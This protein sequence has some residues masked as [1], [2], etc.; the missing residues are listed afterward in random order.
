MVV[1]SVTLKRI[2]KV[3]KKIQI[4]KKK[5]KKNPKNP[6]KNPKNPKKQKKIY[7]IPKK[8]KNY[9]KWSKNLKK[10]E[11][12]PL[13][14]MLSCQFSNIVRTRFDHSSPVQLVAESCGGN[15]EKPLNPL[16]P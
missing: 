8:S 4:K 10:S 15:P 16:N 12:I 6:K 9:P 14:K 2:Q 7:K 3:H 1:T 13:K 5:S 11:K